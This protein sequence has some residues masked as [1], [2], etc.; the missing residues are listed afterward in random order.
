MSNNIIVTDIDSFLA[1]KEPDMPLTPDEFREM[2][3]LF[4]PKDVFVETQKSYTEALLRQ[5]E[6]DR[7]VRETMQT[8][9]NNQSDQET[10]IVHVEDAHVHDDECHQLTEEKVDRKIKL[11][12]VV[13]AI[14]GLISPAILVY[15]SF[16]K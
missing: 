13:I 16:A 7:Q 12:V 4:I 15:N 8:I 2:R 11:A 10:R 14:I 6:T 3:E 1:M 5:A 9:R